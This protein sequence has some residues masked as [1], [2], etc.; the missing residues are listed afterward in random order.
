M[1]KLS[2]SVIVY[3]HNSFK[4]YKKYEMSMMNSKKEAEN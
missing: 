4:D 2:S 3:N 1:S